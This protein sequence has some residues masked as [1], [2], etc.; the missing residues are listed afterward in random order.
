MSF[1]RKIRVAVLRGGPSSEYEVSLKSGGEVLKSLPEKYEGIDV[2]ISKDGVWHVHGIQRSPTD[3]LKH[4]DVAFLALHGQYGEDGKVQ[5]ILDHIGIPY[6]GSEAFASALAMNKHHTKGALK[7]FG[8]KIKLAA[9]KMF[10][11]DDVAKL[12]VHEI[13]R[14]SPHPAAVKPASAGSSVGIAI[15]RNFFELE[16]ALAKALEHSDAV[17][18]EEFVEGRE[19]TCGVLEG[20]RGERL[21]AL[22]TVEIVPKKSSAFFD[23]EAKYGG[24]SLEVCPGNFDEATKRAIE[25]AARAAHQALGLRHYSRSD[26]IV[27]PKRG[28]YFLE[29]NTLPGLTPE[30]LLPKSV[31]AVGASF[32]EFLDHVINLALDRK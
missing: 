11:R 7:R 1:S 28:V 9:H 17:I 25:E 23:Y 26:F 5:R 4:V 12:G 16:E 31:R 3:A 29:V 22:P 27:H 32:P 20:F 21:Y 13:F 30:S 24:E 19:A 8:D 2:F 18:I 6:T 15:V 10:T 14:L